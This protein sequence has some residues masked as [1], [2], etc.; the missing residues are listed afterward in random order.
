MTRVTFLINALCESKICEGNPEQEYLKL[1]NIHNNLLM[2]HSSKLIMHVATSVFI[3][4]IHMPI[5]IYL[6]SLS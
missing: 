2:N 5:F 6:D 3:I 1:P 4:I